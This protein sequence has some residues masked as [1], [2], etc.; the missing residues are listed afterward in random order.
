MKLCGQPASAAVAVR[1]LVDRQGARFSVS[2]YALRRRGAAAP[3]RTP[4][5]VRDRDLTWTLSAH[6]AICRACRSHL[7][8]VV[9]STSN[10][11]GRP[12]TH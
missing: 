12:R 4:G 7:V 6:R 2:P 5:R 8:E 9:A 3:R 1:T 10:E 11:I